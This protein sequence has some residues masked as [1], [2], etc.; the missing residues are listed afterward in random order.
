MILGSNMGSEIRTDGTMETYPH[1]EPIPVAVDPDHSGPS[2]FSSYFWLLLSSV[3]TGTRNRRLACAPQIDFGKR[4]L[5]PVNDDATLQPKAILTVVIAA[6]SQATAVA[7][8]SVEILSL[9][10]P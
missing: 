8:A 4:F 9:D 6:D 7:K 5:S 10:E 3:S 1:V 2:A